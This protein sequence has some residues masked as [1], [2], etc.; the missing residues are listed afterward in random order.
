VGA[1]FSSGGGCLVPYQR[2]G[3]VAGLHI[4]ANAIE[5]K[6]GYLQRHWVLVIG[7]LLA[8]LPF[9]GDGLA[10]GQPTPVLL[11][12]IALFLSRYVERCT[13]AA[14][15][16]LSLAVTIKIF[17]V[18][19]A[20]IPFMRRDWRFML[21]MVSWCGLL[22]VVLPVVC[23]G[24]A[25]ALD[26][27]RAMFT[28]HLGPPAICHARCAADDRAARGNVAP[29]ECEN[30]HWC[31]GRL[32]DCRLA[33]DDRTGS[34]LGLAETRRADVMGPASARSA[35]SHA[36]SA[37]FSSTASSASR[38]QPEVPLGIGRSC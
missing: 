1:A 3:L 26:L 27:Y 35:K 20:V 13:A 22:L 23:V 9:I 30:R 37:R 2:S 36:P 38:R 11:L 28:E 6:A 33:V 19:L 10:R 12:L 16:A 15:F 8:L 34:S 18:V 24:P 31:D 29:Q 25:E 4:W 14:S 17:P 7:A 5:A 32:V 21:W